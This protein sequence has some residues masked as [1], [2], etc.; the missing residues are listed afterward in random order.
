MNHFAD[1]SKLSF[2]SDKPERWSNL[3][4][5]EESRKKIIPSFDGS[6]YD[7]AMCYLS[8]D[9]LAD[10]ILSGKILRISKDFTLVKFD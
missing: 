10:I 2:A 6:T 1:L 7:L 8:K 3:Q 5:L 9:R 4:D